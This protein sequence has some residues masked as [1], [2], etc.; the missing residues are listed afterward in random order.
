MKI[1]FTASA[2]ELNAE[3]DSRFGRCC[4]FLIYDLDVDDYQVF[5]NEQAQTAGGAGVSSAQFLDE[6]GVD[7]VVSGRFGPRAVRALNTAGITIY[8]GAEGT[9][10]EAL[11]DYRAGKLKKTEEATARRHRGRKGLKEE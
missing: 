3:M 5:K 9:V 11:E 10:L 1:A 4:N 6:K 8:S 7:A 2:S